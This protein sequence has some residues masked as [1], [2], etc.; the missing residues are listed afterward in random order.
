VDGIYMLYPE[1]ATDNARFLDL[2]AVRYVFD[3]NGN[4]VQRPRAFGRLNFFF[5]AETIRDDNK[6]LTRLKDSNFDAHKTLLLSD[7]TPLTSAE[8]K[9]AFAVAIDHANPNRVESHLAASSSGYLL[10]ADSYDEGWK[11]YLNGVQTP[12]QAVVF[13]ARFGE[14][15]FVLFMIRRSINATS[16]ELLGSL[17]FS[18]CS[19]VGGIR[20]FFNKKK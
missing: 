16:F 12:I 1:D 4:L 8:L 17:V 6:L 14:Y 13:M 3:E 18:F 19:F 11:V 2:S 5:S 9:E 20:K 10:F 7:S 15:R